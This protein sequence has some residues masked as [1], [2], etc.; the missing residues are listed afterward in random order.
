MMCV[1]VDQVEFCEFYGIITIWLCLILSSVNTNSQNDLI[2][3]DSIAI[4][5]YN[6]YTLRILQPY[7]S[8]N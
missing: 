5:C 8:Y 4:L 3:L 6:L 2:V 1:Y 7:K